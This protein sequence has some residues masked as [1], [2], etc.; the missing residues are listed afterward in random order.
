[1]WKKVPDQNVMNVWTKSKD[2]ECEDQPDVSITPDWYEQNGTPMCMCGCDME[3]SH[4]EVHSDVNDGDLTVVYEMARI[5]F[6]DADIW[7]D[8]ANK[9]DI[10][11]DE[12]NRISEHILKTLGYI[13]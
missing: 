3:Y 6:A 2:C 11:D 1:M 10:P 4:T 7:D 13:Y 9:L 12:M 5:A 8:M